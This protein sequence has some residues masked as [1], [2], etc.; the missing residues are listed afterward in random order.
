MKLG[1]ALPVAGPWATPQNQIRLAQRAEELGYHSVWTA[2]RL[3]YALDPRND[4]PSAPG[5]PWPSPFRS[6][7]DPIV[8]LALVAGVTGRLRLG[9]AVLNMA[10][11][12]PV[13]LAK[14]LAT[15]DLASGGRL[16][17]GLGLG[18]SEDEY[19]ACGVPF[20]D[21]GERADEFLRCLIA[22]WSED[23][24]EFNGRFYRVPRAIVQPKPL[25]SPHPPILLGGYAPAAIRRAATLA[26]GYVGG[27]VPLAQVAPLVSQLREAAVGAGRDPD[28]VRTVSRGA[29]RL[30]DEPQGGDRRPLWGSLGEIKEDIVRYQEA[31]LQELF[32]EMNFDPEI[33]GPDADPKRSLDTALVLLEE[34]A[35]P[36]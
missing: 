21:R 33:A 13:V 24:V 27:N 6:V 29:V 12:A 17:V 8:T 3:L 16:D 10:Y 34:L 35:P 31:G 25:Q 19:D 15:L 4:Y 18:W 11:Y 1:F 9:T 7:V 2:Q 22:L 5:Q 14:Q 20:R 32:I 30:F 26:D 23:P 28:A 36:A